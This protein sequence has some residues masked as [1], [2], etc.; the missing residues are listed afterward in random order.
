METAADIIKDALL[1][2]GVHDAETPLEASE[3]ATGLKYLNRMMSSF[4][5]QGINIGYIPVTN[6]AD[7]V[8]VPEGAYDGIVA[9]LAKRLAQQFGAPITQLLMQNAQDGRKS[10]LRLS[11][12][13]IPSQ[14]PD[15]LPMGS[16]NSGYGYGSSICNDN[17]YPEVKPIAAFISMA[18]N[19]TET[20]ITTRSIAA[21]VLGMFVID[22]S[23]HVACTTAGLCTFDKKEPANLMTN[24]TLRIKSA[25]GDVSV[26]AHIFINGA[27]VASSTIL[28]NDSTSLSVR[29]VHEHRLTYRDTV[30]LYVSNE[31][32]T[33][34]LVVTDCT[35]SID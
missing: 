35:L 22:K 1:E 17:F 3:V 26:K 9:C 13:V 31:T 10:L 24:A 12:K 25:S 20:V 23:N 34:N 19:I 7:Y 11:V 4:A 5:V 14:Y 21:Q 33:A 6:V 18:A 15:T 32:D 30:A 27:S 28:C 16:G 2:I 8:T 29:L